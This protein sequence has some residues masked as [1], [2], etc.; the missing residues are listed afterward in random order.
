M[1]TVAS[2]AALVAVMVTGTAGA[3]TPA[4]APSKDYPY[5][6]DTEFQRTLAPLV[7]HGDRAFF[8]ACTFGDGSRRALVFPVG[9]AKG[10]YAEFSATGLQSQG[11]SVTVGRTVEADEFMGGAQT[12][13]IQMTIVK[14]LLQS[15]FQ[16]VEPARLEWVF[17][18]QRVTQRCAD[19]RG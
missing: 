19:Y 1:R 17:K 3:G 10:F 13:A 15:R 18:H 8:A 14:G 6:N 5:S 4:A 11:A 16:L 2:L 7:A 9:Q 12:M